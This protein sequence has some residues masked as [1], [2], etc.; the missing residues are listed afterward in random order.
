MRVP[1]CT[2]VVTA[3]CVLRISPQV[4]EHNSFLAY[5]RAKYVLDF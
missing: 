2:V 3:P 1:K 4:K 5:V